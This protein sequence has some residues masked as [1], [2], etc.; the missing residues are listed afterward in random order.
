MQ[1]DRP[2]GQGASP[3]RAQ[4]SPCLKLRALQLV[5]MSLAPSLNPLRLHLA[6]FRASW[7]MRDMN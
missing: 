2:Q 5:S 6:C 7:S 3:L 1:I 4:T